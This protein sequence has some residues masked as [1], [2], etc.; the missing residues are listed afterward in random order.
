MQCSHL[1]LPSM[2]PQVHCICHG[3]TYII[4][5]CIP[6]DTRPAALRKQTHTKTWASCETSTHFT[7]F[8][9]KNMSCWTLTSFS[10]GLFS[11]SVA[12]NPGVSF[13]F[14]C[15]WSHSESYVDASLQVDEGSS[16]SECQAIGQNGG[17]YD[18]ERKGRAALW[19]QCP[20]LWKSWVEETVVCVPR[21]TWE[22]LKG[23]F[24]PRDFFPEFS[25]RAEI[26]IVNFNHSNNIASYS[27]II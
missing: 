26:Q 12:E 9:W 4:Y 18:F 23:L 11:N 21:V 14:L 3:N 22:A 20:T 6:S 5:A 10:Q 1:Y 16:G 24:S 27:V 15:L 25:L 8:W 17:D 2:Q 13:F 7:M 19:P